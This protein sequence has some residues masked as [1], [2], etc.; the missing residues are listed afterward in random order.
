MTLPIGTRLGP[1]E[2]AAMLGAGGMGEVYLARD[3]RLERDVAIKVLSAA[4]TGPEHQDRIP[5]TAGRW[6]R[7]QVLHV[8][9][10]AQ[11][12]AYKYSI[13]LTPSGKRVDPT[14]IIDP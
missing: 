2:I 3:T 10:N 5:T 7:G 14:I 12:G 11:P 13:V 4:G 6:R 1:Y 8:K 9:P